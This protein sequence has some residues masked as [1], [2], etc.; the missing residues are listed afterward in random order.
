[1]T[2]NQPNKRFFFRAAMTLLMCVLTTMTAWA[3]DVV[4]Y[5]PTVPTDQQMKTATNAIEITGNTTSLGTANT[6]T[7]YYVSGSFGNDNRIEVRGTVNIILAN[8]CHINATDGFHVPS[9]NTLNIYAQKAGDFDSGCGRLTADSWG[10]AAIGGNGGSNQIGNGGAGEDAGNITIY[11]GIINTKAGI[12]G[13]KG[14]YGMSDYDMSGIGGKGGKG[15]HGGTIT[16]YGGDIYSEGAIGG[17][18]GGDGD[19]AYGD[20]GDGLVVLSWTNMSDWIYA[21][22]FLGHVRLLKNFTDGYGGIFTTTEYNGNTKYDGNCPLS[23][24]HLEPAPVSYTITINSGYD[25]PCLQSS[26]PEA[27]EGYSVTLTAIN[28]YTVS[29]VTVKDADNGNVSVTDNHNGTWTFTMP[30]KNVTVTATAS[31]THYPITAGND[32][33]LSASE[34]DKL[35]QNG[36]TYYKAGATIPFTLTPPDETHEVQT[37]SITRDDNNNDVAWTLTG[38][39]YTFTMPAAATTISNTWQRVRFRITKTD[40]MTLS[41]SEGGTVTINS[42]VYYK[43]GATVTVTVTPPEGYMISFFRVKETDSGNDVELTNEEN[44]TFTY[45]MPA[46]DVTLEALYDIDTSDLRLFEGTSDFTVTNGL[47]EIDALTDNAIFSYYTGNDYDDDKEEGCTKLLDGDDYTKWC[48][49]Y[50]N[51]CDKDNQCFVEFNT[52]QPVVPKFYVLMTG[53][54]NEVYPGRNPGSWKI[55]AKVNADDTDWD[56]IAN[57]SNNTTMEDKDNASY[58]FSFNNPE[59]VAYQYFRFEVTAVQGHWDGFSFNNDVM[60]LSEMQ[61]WVK[62]EQPHPLT[63]QNVK[64]FLEGSYEPITEAVAGETIVVSADPDGAPEGKYF[65]KAYST[66]DVTLTMLDYYDATF[67]MPAKAVTVDAILADQTE[68]VINLTTAEPQTV[69]QW[70]WLILMA[71]EG[72]AQYDEAFGSFVIDVNRDG[73]PDVQLTNNYTVTRLNSMATNYRFTLIYDFQCPYSTALFKFTAS[74]EVQNQPTIVPGD[75]NGDG[76]I[77]LADAVSIVNYILGHPSPGF[78]PG[79]ADA[80]KDDRVT[81][82]DAVTV[83]GMIAE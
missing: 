25:L 4:Y 50:F 73:T 41:V 47:S 55:L 53:D 42:H 57:V 30:G 14:G 3:D 67:T 33:G 43:P 59:N 44:N 83:L 66:S 72:Y 38:G 74:D 21:F 6:E 78:V 28:G 58:S 20:P 29:D 79:A 71:M 18:E 51:A 32:V 70:L 64:F 15:G 81:I 75:A 77:T 35:V 56:V 31:R 11:G 68:G 63:G 13:G 34:S 61:M 24:R 36:V 46:A 82:S 54:D 27:Y 52:A 22:D 12:G 80:N 76:Q 39:T 60:Q 49:S 2:A 7:W 45:T 23:G 37:F 19:D 5:D 26:T 9:G 48:L 40:D 1:M 65:T 8:G 17:G 69:D 62:E 16:I 10:N